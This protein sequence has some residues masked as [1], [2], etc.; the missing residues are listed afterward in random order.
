MN[1]IDRDNGSWGVGQRVEDT[2]VEGGA[3]M[4]G[5]GI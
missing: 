1:R 4:V 2:W 5:G 3:K